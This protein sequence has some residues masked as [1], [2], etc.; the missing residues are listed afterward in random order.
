MP[1]VAFPV[2]IGIMPVLQSS[3]ATA[4]MSTSFIALVS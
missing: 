2:D 3:T 1:L 4:L